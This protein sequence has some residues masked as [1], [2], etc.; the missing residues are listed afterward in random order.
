MDFYNYPPGMGTS[1]FEPL[2]GKNY[3]V[4]C[5]KFSY[6][7]NYEEIGNITS[8][9]DERNR[10]F[11]GDYVINI[12][13]RVSIIKKGKIIFTNNH[14][15]DGHIIGESRL[16]NNPNNIQYAI[17]TDKLQEYVIPTWRNDTL[18]TYSI[19]DNNNPLQLKLY[20]STEAAINHAILLSQEKN[21]DCIVAQW[22]GDI[23]R[24]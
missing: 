17:L 15:E 9:F 11:S 10:F 13:K 20:S 22:F 1:P 3:F 14:F 2:E 6:L 16:K 23:D 5:S 4:Y 12:F 7:G 19:K 8:P 21:M 18:K 24:H